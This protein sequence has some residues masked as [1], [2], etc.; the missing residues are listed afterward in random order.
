V[1]DAE[2]IASSLQDGAAFALLFDRHFRAV[3]RFLAARV[4]RELADDLSSETFTV[5]FRRRHSYDLSRADARPWL[6]GIAVNL[7]R[8][9][10]RSE[11]RRLRA[12][13]RSSSATQR[14]S[15]GQLDAGVASALLAL[16]LEERNLLLLFAWAELGYQELSE[17]LGLPV[18][19]VRSRLSRLRAKLRERLDPVALELGAPAGSDLL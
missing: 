16:T 18:G 7:L 6:Y 11:N 12:Y 10:R 2:V 5:A 1:S 13:E 3:Y 9:H 8:E 14:A 19:T 15:H 4:G 17:A